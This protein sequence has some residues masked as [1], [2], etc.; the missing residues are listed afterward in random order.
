MRT[1][2]TLGFLSLIAAAAFVGCGDDDGGTTA[3]GGS[4][5]TGGRAGSAGMGGGGA[6]GAQGGSGGAQG[7]SG[8]GG[9]GGTGPDLTPI[10]TCTGCVELIAPVTG[11]NDNGGTTNLN[12][13]VS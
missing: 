9:A 2:V 7:G 4:A 11:P 8:G 6:G 3:Q 5:G 13:Q 12:D 1:S 10:A